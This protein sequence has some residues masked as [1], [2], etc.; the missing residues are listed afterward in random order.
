VNTPDNDY[1]SK[2][3]FD[4]YTKA[5]AIQEECTGRLELS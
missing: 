2:E 5:E 3:I 1:V 4:V